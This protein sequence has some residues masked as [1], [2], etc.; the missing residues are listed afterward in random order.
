MNRNSD[1]NQEKGNKVLTEL[2]KK[3]LPPQNLRP[4]VHRQ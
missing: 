2:L 3:M 4:M 1:D